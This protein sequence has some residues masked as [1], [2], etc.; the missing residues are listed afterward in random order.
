MFFTA[1]LQRLHSSVPKGSTWRKHLL[2]H[3]TTSKKRLGKLFITKHEQKA[4]N[5]YKFGLPPNKR[6]R[7]TP[8]ARHKKQG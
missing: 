8:I 6:Y 5:K 2:K 3:K 1:R 7:L 4:R